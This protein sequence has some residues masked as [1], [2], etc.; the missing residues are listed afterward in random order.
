ML[1]IVVL[2]AAA[3]GGLPQWNC[4]CA[5]CAQAWSDPALRETQASLAAS[6]DGRNWF[7]INASPDLRAQILAT[8]QLHPQEGSLRHSPIAGVIL[9][10]GEIDAVTG[11]LSMREGQPFALHAHPRVLET[12]A[13]NSLFNVL[14]PAKV[15][16]LP[17]RPGEPFEPLLP[18]GR[19][20][21]LLIEAFDAPGKPAWYLET[22]AEAPKPAEGDTLGLTL[23]DRASGARA[24]VLLACAAMTPDL[25]ERLRGADLLFFDGTLWRDDEMILSGLSQKTGRRMGHLSISGPEGSM[26][27]LQDLEIRRKVFLHVNNS[28]P[29]WLPDSPERAAVEAA[30]WSLPR[31]G[32][33]FAA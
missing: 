12:L 11:L 4:R 24:H 17:L 19:P 29:V 7:L 14:D 26:A 28:N 10:N 22:A 8:P 30:G 9:T 16:R 5:V 25:A 32:E 31:Q 23:A 33:E 3:G 18:D 21:G 27:L 2:G 1:K 13:A 20:S 15:P 6:V